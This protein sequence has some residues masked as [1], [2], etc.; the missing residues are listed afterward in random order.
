MLSG[1]MIAA[2]RAF[3]RPMRPRFVTDKIFRV[4][5]PM[6]DEVE[7]KDGKR[8]ITPK[9]VF[10]GCVLL[11]PR[12]GRASDRFV[13]FV[14]RCHELSWSPRSATME[15]CA[16]RIPTAPSPGVNHPR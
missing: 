16:T 1:A 9:N 6:E 2:L 14:R 11:W 8:K 5:V 4:L 7:F 3:S 15:A 10:P 12:P 13:R